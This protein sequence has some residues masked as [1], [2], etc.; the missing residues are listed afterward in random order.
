LRNAELEA[1]RV[2]CMVCHARDLEGLVED[3]NRRPD[4]YL[5]RPTYVGLYG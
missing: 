4:D 3:L 5:K 1:P 2:S